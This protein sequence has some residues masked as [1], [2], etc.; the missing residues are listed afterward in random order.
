METYYEPDRLLK[1]DNL[2]GIQKSH[3]F[4]YGVVIRVHG[5]M[6]HKVT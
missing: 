4:F 3:V 6:V 5:A 1:H 2:N